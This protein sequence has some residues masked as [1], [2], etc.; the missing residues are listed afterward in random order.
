RPLLRHGYV[1]QRI[2]AGGGAGQLARFEEPDHSVLAVEAWG[3]A[4]LAAAQPSHGLG[5]QLAADPADLLERGAQQDLQ[6]GAE[7]GDQ[8]GEPGLDGLRTRA[9]LVDLA[10]YLG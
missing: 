8:R 1:E 4:H 3:A 2:A 9:D 5:Q 10:E 7:G 6:L